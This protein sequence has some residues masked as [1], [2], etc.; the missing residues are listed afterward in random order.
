MI[1]DILTPSNF[2]APEKTSINDKC[3]IKSLAKELNN[4]G[5]LHHQDL[6]R[7][8]RCNNKNA[9]LR[10]CWLKYNKVMFAQYAYKKNLKYHVKFKTLLDSEG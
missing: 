1:T 3:A 6:V 9:T 8:L 5:H 10:C 2:E 4:N 7:Y